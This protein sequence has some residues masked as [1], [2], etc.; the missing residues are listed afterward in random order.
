MLTDYHG[1][2]FS[3]VG[4]VFIVG[5]E[6]QWQNTHFLDHIEENELK[7]LW[8]WAFVVEDLKDLIKRAH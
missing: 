4:G 5:Q 1:D 8:C 3:K 7:P 2:E 6:S